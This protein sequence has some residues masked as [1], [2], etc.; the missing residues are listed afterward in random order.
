MV[1]TRYLNLITD[2]YLK[3]FDLILCRNVIKFF[4]EDVKKEVHRKLS[5]SLNEGGILV[6]SDELENEGIH[7]PEKLR[8]RQVNNS[9]IY[10]KI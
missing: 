8:L 10:C 1:E 7:E 9:C 3:G 2:E 4:T 6:V 5:E